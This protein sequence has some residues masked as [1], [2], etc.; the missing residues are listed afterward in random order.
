MTWDDC[1]E[2]EER[3][4]RELEEA[5]Q[6]RTEAEAK[7]AAMHN[8][9]LSTGHYTAD[10]ELLVA[11]IGELEAERDQLRHDKVRLGI[12]ITT[13]E[14]RIGE[15]EAALRLVL[16]EDAPMTVIVEAAR[17]ALQ[18]TTEGLLAGSPAEQEVLG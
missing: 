15:L 3:L 1:A 6:K 11:H 16:D 18:P 13:L 8:M 10:Q 12:G 14:A 9:A 2:R 5:R 7:A 17:R 4:E